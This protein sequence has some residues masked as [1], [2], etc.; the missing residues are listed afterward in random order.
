MGGFGQ[1]VLGKEGVGETLSPARVLVLWVG[2]CWRTAAHFPCGPRWLSGCGKSLDPISVGSGQGAVLG[3]RFSASG[4][5]FTSGHCR[6]AEYRMGAPGSGQLA[7]G[8]KGGEGRGRGHCVVP[9]R[10]RVLGWSAGRPSG[11]RLDTAH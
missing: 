9:M 7:L 10:A 2:K 8:P 1:W 3:T 11:R 4:I 6:G 5:P